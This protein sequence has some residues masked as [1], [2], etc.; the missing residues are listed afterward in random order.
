MLV[1]LMVYKMNYYHLYAEKT[2]PATFQ[3]PVNCPE[4][5]DQLWYIAISTVYVIVVV[6]GSTH[7][8]LTSRLDIWKVHILSYVY[9][10]V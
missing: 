4:E 6:S 7:A 10:N 5:K 3:A 8:S 2:M 1:V 9:A